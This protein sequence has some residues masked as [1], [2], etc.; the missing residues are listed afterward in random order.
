MGS[1]FR[2]GYIQNIHLFEAMPENDTLCNCIHLFSQLLRNCHGSFV[3]ISFKGPK[4]CGNKKS[5]QFTGYFKIN[6]PCLP[7]RLGIEELRRKE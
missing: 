5:H 1:T 3:A 6:G 4:G 7:S 2:K